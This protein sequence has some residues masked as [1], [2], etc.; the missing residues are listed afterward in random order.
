MEVNEERPKLTAARKGRVVYLPS[1]I[2]RSGRASFKNARAVIIYECTAAAALDFNFCTRKR[3]V[4][5]A[6]L[7]STHIQPQTQSPLKARK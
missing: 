7:F 5:N 1:A 6:G 4:N 2:K 3:A